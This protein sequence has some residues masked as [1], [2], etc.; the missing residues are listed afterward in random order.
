M[1]EDNFNSNSYYGYETYEQ[2]VT[3][4]LSRV[5]FEENV[6]AQSF[7]FMF[8]ALIITGI[9]SFLTLTTGLWYALIMQRS[10]FWGLLIAELVIVF[11]ANYTVAKNMLVP[12]ALLFVGYSVVNGVV[13]SIIFLAYTYSSIASVFF[14]AAVLF[15]VMAVYGI[16]TKTDL[17]KIGNICLMALV[18]LILVSVINMLFLHLESLELA[19]C[20]IGVL[21]F[22]GITAYDTQKIKAMTAASTSDNATVLAL[23]GALQLYLD[24]IN[25]FL[26]L[27]RLLGKRRN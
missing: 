3:N 1:N 10:L 14:L 27:L 21:L 25:I 13:L 8:I 23:Y 26:K 12:S 9:T 4:D 7:L 24:F 17:S 20:F 22:V 19:L 11:A 16:V 2:P 15:G 5:H 18:G 6:L